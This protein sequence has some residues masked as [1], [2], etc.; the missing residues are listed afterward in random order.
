MIQIEGLTVAYGRTI[1]LDAIDLTLVDGVTGLFG[2][3]A[4]G[5]ST[6]L[7][8]LAGLLTPTAGTVV[9]DGRRVTASDELF[10]R[11]VGY[12]G[13]SSGLYPELS[14][15]ENLDLFA[16]L[17]GADPGRPA[18]LVEQVGLAARARTRV[19]ELS[20]GLKRRA[21]VARALV[22]DPEVLLLDEPYANLDDDAAGLV[23]RSIVEWRGPGK[24]AVVAS[25]GAKR[26]KGFADA[27]IILQRGTVVSYRTR[28]PVEAVDT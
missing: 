24:I 16:A 25:H 1:A 18:H 3:N 23:S 11:R 2:Q 5:K 22:H 13:H 6:L 20:A 21:A 26:V 17:Y 8:V 7:R 27:S 4:A 28:Q 14:V 19:A 10:R 15:R 9:I 12:A